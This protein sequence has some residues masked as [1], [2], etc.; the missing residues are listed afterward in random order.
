MHTEQASVGV[1][2][3]NPVAKSITIKYTEVHTIFIKIIPS[4]PTFF[5][6]EKILYPECLHIV[7]HPDNVCY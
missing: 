2:P 7:Y 4:S 5:T 6:G 1:N 3:L